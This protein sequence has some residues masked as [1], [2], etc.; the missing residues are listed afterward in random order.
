MTKTESMKLYAGRI[1]LF[2]AGGLL[3]FAVM[4]FTVVNTVKKQNE[5]LT[6]TLDISR[7][8]PGRL[9]ADAEAQLESKNYI[10]A[11]ESLTTLFTNQPGW[12]EAGEGKALMM[13]IEEAEKVANANWEAAMPDVKQK[14][15][16]E[17]AAEIL[18]KSDKERTVLEENMDETI[19]KEW[20]KVKSEVREEWEKE[21]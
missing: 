2:L 19:N 14:W 3:V 13:I 16:E 21:G 1:A 4:S 9:L 11:K 10:E 7:Y 20:E 17:L 8:E 12:E 5:E 18:T 15:S 6:K